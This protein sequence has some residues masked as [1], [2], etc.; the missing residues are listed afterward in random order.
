MNKDEKKPP[1][2]VCMS[3]RIFLLSVCALILIAIID[4]DLVSG[5]SKLSPLII[6]ILFVSIFAFF[7]II[8]LIFE[9]MQFKS[10]STK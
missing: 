10:K 1:C 5:I 2:R 4:R 7:S 3:I 6:A 8:K 9:F